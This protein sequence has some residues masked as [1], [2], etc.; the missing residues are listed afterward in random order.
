MRGGQAGLVYPNPVYVHANMWLQ[1]TYYTTM[2]NYLP[3]LAG[4]GV[5]CMPSSYRDYEN[6]EIAKDVCQFIQSPGT[7][8]RERTQLFKL[9]WEL[10][11]RNFRTAPAI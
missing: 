7:P 3:N 5:I 10:M 6:P 8:S 2:L 9:A 1:A 11:V 4:A